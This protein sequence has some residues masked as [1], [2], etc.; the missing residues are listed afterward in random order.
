METRICAVYNLARGILLNSKLT[1]IDCASQPLRILKLMV[2]GLGLD[3]VSGL[4]LIPLHGVPGVPRVF[5]FDLIYLD[6]EHRVVAAVEM[7]PGIEFPPYR[8]QIASALVLPSNALSSTGTKPGDQLIVC[9]ADELNAL[10]VTAKLG[11]D[12]KKSPASAEFA[13]S[14][15]P[16][17]VSAVK[18][19]VEKTPAQVLARHVNGR[20]SSSTSSEKHNTASSI[21]QL[22]NKRPKEL[23]WESTT[24]AN[25]HN[26]VP[27]APTSGLVLKPAAPKEP[28]M[29]PISEARAPE[30]PAP[31]ENL[32]QRGSPQRT[33]NSQPFPSTTTFATSPFS[34]WHVSPP[35]AIAPVMNSSSAST[36]AKQNGGRGTDPQQN[37]VPKPLEVRRTPDPASKKISSPSTPALPVPQKSSTMAGSDIGGRGPAVAPQKATGKP[38]VQ[39]KMWPKVPVATSL[40]V[41]GK[42]LPDVRPSLPSESKAETKKPEIE[43]D[44]PAINKSTGQQGSASANEHS[45]KVLL[46]RF[47]K[48]EQEGQ[49]KSLDVATSRSKVPPLTGLRSK[50]KQW[51]K[52]AAHPSDR[53]HA[54]RRY[55]PGMYAHYYTGGAPKPHQVADISMSGFY[56]LTED[57][58]MA[59]TMI[60]M[61]LQKPCAKGQ[62]R[63]SITVLSRIVRRG[64]DGVAAEFVMPESIDSQSQDLLPSQATDRFALA[65]FL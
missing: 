21:E 65:R 64:S 6:K 62:Q 63:Q 22:S 9:S 43:P 13:Q 45:L 1:V 32:S 27:S 39:K 12:Q 41:A 59:G 25:V 38:I 55:V 11:P 60:Q 36:P 56:L 47:L 58:W 50:F 48:L 7:G 51:L 5:P 23:T 10:L 34:L 3:S 19:S 31:V 28:E 40:P 49:L 61:T 17:T 16:E 30:K 2:G 24:G 26:R 46:P 15:E 4:W 54:Q 20:D 18:S 33:P 57:R 37:G 44:G 42:S 29:D 52:P 8:E 14:K 53:R 35:T